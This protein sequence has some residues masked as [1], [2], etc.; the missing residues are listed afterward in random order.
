MRPALS[1]AILLSLQAA[2]LAAQDPPKILVRRDVVRVAVSVTDPSGR[3]IP[4]L[5][6]G[7][8]QILE[9]GV[10]QDITHFESEVT[11]LTVVLLLEDSKR[12]ERVRFVIL[13][14]AALFLT[15][16]M[17]PEDHAALVTYDIRPR[18]LQD[19]SSSPGQLLEALR[20]LNYS[21]VGFR[22]SNLHRALD[23][24]LR[25]G[26]LRG[27]DYQGLERLDRRTAIL[28]VASGH[29]STSPQNYEETLRL[30]S[31]AGVPVYTIDVGK[32][33]LDLADY[34]QAR[35]ALRHFARVSGG[36]YQ[37]ARDR[38]T[39]ESVLLLT[40]QLLRNQYA[41]AYTPSLTRRQ[42]K[43]RRIEVLIDVDRDGKPDNKR[44]E[45]RHRQFYYEPGGTP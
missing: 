6:E 33:V 44:L 36:S 19:F 35:N 43:R 24:V 45:V 32:A 28:L 8:F 23:F 12:I 2:H 3:P 17:R 30:V 27:Q 37:P 7:D 14:T 26:E 16:V 1:A 42:G 22:E 25:G 29:D 20:G 5:A 31:Q 41:L 39:M 18:V 21:P 9:D 11:P 38:V 40:A 34:A 13:E 10:A 15:R 4:Q